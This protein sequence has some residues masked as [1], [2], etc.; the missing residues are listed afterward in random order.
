MQTLAHIFTH[1]HTCKYI[2]YTMHTHSKPNP[3]KPTHA[4]KH[5]QK[6]KQHQKEFLSSLEFGWCLMIRE[7]LNFWS[8]QRLLPLK[9][10]LLIVL[11]SITH[12]WE[13]FNKII[14]N[15]YSLWWQS[16]YVMNDDQAHLRLIPQDIASS[17]LCACAKSI[18]LQHIKQ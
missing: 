4:H 10:Q 18:Q 1:I 8:S 11:P 12:Q 7:N 16:E 3:H 6:S 9:K 13:A 2:S 15:G 5:T 14:T 17:T